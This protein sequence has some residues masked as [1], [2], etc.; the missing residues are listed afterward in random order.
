MSTNV[1]SANSE[2]NDPDR[3]WR[4]AFKP[5]YPMFGTK[6]PELPRLK[7]HHSQDIIARVQCLFKKCVYVAEAQRRG[8]WVLVN[9]QVLPNDGGLRFSDPQWCRDDCPWMG[10]YPCSGLNEGSY[11]KPV[12]L[13]NTALQNAIYQLDNLYHLDFSIVDSWKALE[14]DMDAVSSELEGELK[15]LPS[16]RRP[17]GPSRYRYDNRYPDPVDAYNSARYA[18]NAFS[19]FAAYIT[20]LMSFWHFPSYHSP[21][22]PM[23]A[24]VQSRNQV[25]RLALPKMIHDSC[26]ADFRLGIRAGLMF[27]LFNPHAWLPYIHVIAEVGVPIWLYCGEHPADQIQ[28][29]DIPGSPDILNAARIWTP[30]HVVEEL[31]FAK[32]LSHSI[33]LPPEISNPFHDET[34]TNKGVCVLIPRLTSFARPDNDYRPGCHP[35]YFFAERRR[36]IRLW[37][38]APYISETYKQVANAESSRTVWEDHLKKMPMFLWYKENDRWFREE[39]HTANKKYLWT[40]HDHT[41]RFY[42]PTRRQFDLCWHLNP[43]AGVVDISLAGNDIDV[44]APDAFDDLP[45]P[46]TP[47]PSSEVPQPAIPDTPESPEHAHTPIARGSSLPYQVDPY[48]DDESDYG[49]DLEDSPRPPSMPGP[50]SSTSSSALP[51]PRATLSSSS[52]ITCA[53]WGWQDIM[54][55]RFGYR[56]ELPDISAGGSNEASLPLDRAGQFLGTKNLPETLSS[57]QKESI[58]AIARELSNKDLNTGDLNPRWDISD[59]TGCLTLPALYQ[60]QRIQ[61]ARGDLVTARYIVGVP[62]QSLEQQWWVLVVT[63]GTLLD[64]L[65]SQGGIMASARNLAA[66]GVRFWTARFES[67]SVKPQ[68]EDIA[69]EGIGAVME[70]SCVT[71]EQYEDYERI[72]DAF[73]D[74]PRGHLALKAGGIIWRLSKHKFELRAA[75]SAP[76]TQARILGQVVGRT[77]THT[78]VDDVLRDDEKDIILGSYALRGREPDKPECVNVQIWPS[79]YAFS[80]AGFNI[81]QWTDD[82]ERWFNNHLAQ[83]RNGRAKPKVSK[84]WRSELRMYRGPRTAWLRYEEWADEYAKRKLL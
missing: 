25:A 70:G 53:L 47:T 67:L 73:L 79:E 68:P 35:D 28:T 1:Q 2:A 76:S 82:C 65:R 60:I 7:D 5:R 43:D 78:L 51:A 64:V 58:V 84:A 22:E 41:Q 56:P 19:Q 23:V 24:L 38:N 63:P 4:Y 27:N 18:R 8:Y 54:L 52:R 3:L 26:I 36:D 66:R 45:L 72:R 44:I 49:D 31:A 29:H 37:M 81:G 21:L 34:R 61:Y 16:F 57:S 39:I 11:L 59:G 69:R 10:Y 15:H 80:A 14:A 9:T 46:H 77:S 74:S 32:F 50:R 6:R 20:F 12:Q 33:L 42:S 83:I 13:P 40:A 62:T 71:P 55:Y 75:T 17:P 48:V 30:S